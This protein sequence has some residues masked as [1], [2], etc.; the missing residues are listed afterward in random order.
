MCPEEW[1]VCD[2]TMPPGGPHSCEWLKDHKEINGI[3]KHRCV[4]GSTRN[5]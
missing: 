3:M 2:Q 1:G 5:A 4:C